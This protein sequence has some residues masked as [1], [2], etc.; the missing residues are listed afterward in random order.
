MSTRRAPP[1]RPARH[2]RRPAPRRRAARGEETPRGRADWKGHIAFGLVEI[3]VALRSAE[4]RSEELHFS[5]VDRRD[6]APVGNLRVNKTT[7]EEVPWSEIVKGYEH[8]KGDFV[9]LDESELR[10][11]NVEATRTIDIVDFVDASAIHPV[12]FE[13]PYHV[14]PARPRGNRAYALLHAALEA[15]GKVGI[16]TVVLRTRQHLAAL[17]T[18]GPLLALVLLRWA[19]ELADAASVPLPADSRTRVPERELAMARQ[20]VES[21]SS[22]WTPARYKDTYHA[23]VMQLIRR[24]IR[25]GRT[26]PVNEP[27]PED[28]EQPVS[29]VLDLMPLMQRSLGGRSRRAPARRPAPRARRKSA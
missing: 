16:A 13:E 20:L 9:L 29:P 8:H 15:T 2:G 4:R 19:H 10:R 25:S 18:R 6:R 24:K 21:M 27:A 5:L 7:G 26:G 17:T 28:E 3:P 22:A 12:Y 23:D 1:R 14:L 11:V